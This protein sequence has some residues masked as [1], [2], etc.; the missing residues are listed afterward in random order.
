MSFRPAG[1]ST[2]MTFE[3]GQVWQE[4]TEN[5][6]HPAN[7]IVAGYHICHPIPLASRW[8]DTKYA[9][10]T[11]SLDRV[12]AM[13]WYSLILHCVIRKSRVTWATA[14]SPWTRS[15]P[16][17]VIMKSAV[18][19][20]K[21]SAPLRALLVDSSFRVPSRWSMCESTRTKCAMTGKIRLLPDTVPTDALS[22]PDIF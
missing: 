19:V 9:S 21:I 1:W 2:P 20:L 5:M 14:L 22:T 16:P 6:L 3:F 4:E 12:S 11:V 18:S 15:L 7:V 8:S 13:M 17:E 10:P